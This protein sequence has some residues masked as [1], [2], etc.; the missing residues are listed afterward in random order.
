MSPKPGDP[1][2]QI[3]LFLSLAAAQPLTFLSWLGVLNVSGTR[4]PCRM[5]SGCNA[6]ILASNRLD[7]SQSFHKLSPLPQ[8]RRS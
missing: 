5:A 1:F 3:K 4:H 6:R 7:F 8:V 2:G